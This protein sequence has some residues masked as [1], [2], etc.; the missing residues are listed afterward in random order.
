MSMLSIPSPIY[1]SSHS[2]LSISRL[3]YSLTAQPLQVSRRAKVRGVVVMSME[4]GIGVMA[5]KL[6]MMSFFQPDGEVVPV[7]VVGFKEGNIVTQIKTEA[8][9]GY[10]SVQ[11]GYRRVRDRKLTKPE[12]GHLEKVGAIPM[13]HLQEF[14]LQTVDQFELNQR[15]V[16]DE[17][18]KEGDLVDV[19]GTT[20]GKGFQGG[21]KRH[22]FK[23]GPMTH[24]SKSHRQLG[25]IGAGTTPGRVYKGKK[26][27]G[28]MG[29][30]KRKIR[31]LKI[32]KIDKDLNVVM[33][34]G[35]LPGKPGNLL[36][37]TPAKIV[38]KNIP[39]N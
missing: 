36:R 19:S 18:F 11:V 34:K 39:K 28:R 21:I 7:T 35:A 29:G 9:D 16:F 33:I 32:V 37:I 38:G 31:K 2:S 17:L 30:T 6:G 10:D 4:A 3:P 14:R 26:M 24:G 25:S 23:R 20:I 1:G 8:T 27:P 5:T 13:R 15:L 12:M 22:N